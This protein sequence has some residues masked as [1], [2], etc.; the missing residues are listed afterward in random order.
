MKELLEKLFNETVNVF[1][2]YT[3]SEIEV[4]N[5]DES[6]Y[7]LCAVLNISGDYRGMTL[8]RINED[9]LKDFG[10]SKSGNDFMQELSHDLR[11]RLEQMPLNL[12]LNF[13]DP[14]VVTGRDFRISFPMKTEI[15]S[16]DLC[17][18]K[19]VRTNIMVGLKKNEY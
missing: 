7:D 9:K 8:I 6:K 14:T 13:S 1:S 12:R 17:A 10:V 5:T 16:R 11:T 19:V 3:N 18:D 15:F 4:R 2:E